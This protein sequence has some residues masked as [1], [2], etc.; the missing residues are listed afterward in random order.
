M[1]REARVKNVE[2]GAYWKQGR[3]ASNYGKTLHTDG[4]NVYSY[5][6]LIGITDKGKKVLFD[7]TATGGRFISDTTSHH[8]GSLR[9]YC[10]VTKE[11]QNDWK[12]I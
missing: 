8:V 7:Y 12:R 2:V 5:Y 6:L 11:V 10:D 3:P 9:G 1:E 4:L